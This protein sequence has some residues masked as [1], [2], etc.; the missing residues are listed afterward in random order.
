MPVSS[1]GKFLAGLGA[2]LGLCLTGCQS[3]CL[4][5][6]SMEKIRN[7]TIEPAPAADPGNAF[8]FG[9]DALVRQRPGRRRA[10]RQRS[11]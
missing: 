10:A 8:D 6:A 5:C 3:R 9:S 4:L 11:R 7:T 1:H 2:L